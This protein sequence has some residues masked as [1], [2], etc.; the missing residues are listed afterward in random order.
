MKWRNADEIVS[1][2]DIRFLSKEHKPF[3][4][5]YSCLMIDLESYYRT[6]YEFFYARLSLCLIS[7][8]EGTVLWEAWIIFEFFNIN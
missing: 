6:A 7:D 4:T 8:I 2:G 5:L 3:T 1:L